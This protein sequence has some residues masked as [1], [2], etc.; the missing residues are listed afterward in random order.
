MTQIVL[1][2][3]HIP[4]PSADILKIGPGVLQKENA[5]EQE[6]IAT[7]AGPLIQASEPSLVWI[8]SRQKKV[9]S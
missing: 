6:L 2:G 5:S 1:P 8:D 4:F 9:R 3:D 7:K